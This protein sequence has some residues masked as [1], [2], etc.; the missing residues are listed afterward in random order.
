[1]HPDF[2]D[3]SSKYSETVDED[4]NRLKKHF[5]FR[6]GC[7]DFMSRDCDRIHLLARRPGR[8]CRSGHELHG[9]GGHLSARSAACCALVGGSRQEYPSA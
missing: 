4:V 9:G 7:S 1:M 8:L 2:L 6:S 3:N 5:Q